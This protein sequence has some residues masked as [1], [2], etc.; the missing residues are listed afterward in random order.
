MGKYGPNCEG[1]CAVPETCNSKPETR[2][3]KPETRKHEPESRIPNP[4]TRIQVEVALA[5]R[6]ARD[7]AIHEQEKHFIT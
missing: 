2:N 5:E 1:R 6:R 7:E 3:P 4:K